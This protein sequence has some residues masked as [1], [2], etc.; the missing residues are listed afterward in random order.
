MLQGGATLLHH[1]SHGKFY[2]ARLRIRGRRVTH[3]DLDI[4][5]ETVRQ[6]TTDEKR[7]GEFICQGE[8]SLAPLNLV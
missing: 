2:V 8:M 6:E 7:K 5:L 4:N 1:V 3:L